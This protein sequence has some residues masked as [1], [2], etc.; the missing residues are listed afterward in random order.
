MIRN[1]SPANLSLL[2]GFS[3]PIYAEAY[4][5]MHGFDITLDVLLVNQTANT[6]KTFFWIS[7]HWA[8]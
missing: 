8:I 2:L 5:K 7:L 1:V 3:D 4:V 6:F